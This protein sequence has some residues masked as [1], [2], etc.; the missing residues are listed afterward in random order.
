MDE[1]EQ[2]VETP[3]EDDAVSRVSEEKSTKDDIEMM[4]QN[5][6]NS[7]LTDQLLLQNPENENLEN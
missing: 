4:Y 1:H 3:A 7:G 5:I 2:R 6:D